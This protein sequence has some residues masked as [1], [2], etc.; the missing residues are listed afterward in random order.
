MV[1]IAILGYGVVGSGVYEVIRKNC[2]SITRK[3]G[4]EIDVKYILDIR[5]FPDHPENWLFTKDFDTILNDDDVSIVVEVMGG[6]EPA[7]PYTKAAL[8]KGKNVVTS[9][10]ELVAT[11]GDELLQIAHDNG[12]CYLFEA[13]VGG[14]IPIIRP[15]NQ[16]LAGNEITEIVGILNGTTNYILTQMIKNG[17]AFEDALKDAQDK[18]FAERNPAADV[19]G[20][21]A[22]RKICILASLA[23]GKKIAYDKVYTEGITNLTLRD[24]GYADELGS[25]IKL[26]GYCRKLDNGKVDI[27]VAPMMVADEQPLSTVAGVYN[28]IQVRGNAIGDAMFYGPGAGKLPTASAVVGDIIDIAKNPGRVGR[29]LWTDTK[30]DLILDTNQA[31]CAYFVRIAAQDKGKAGADVKALFGEVTVIDKYEDELGFLT[32]EMSE[33]TLKEKLTG[34]PYRVVG[35]IRVLS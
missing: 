3:A 22:C 34:L 29:V 1:N 35:F 5:Q 27:K 30:E 31:V 28:G 33:G 15:L 19:E 2:E 11:Y 18:G 21:D 12:V 24:T 4:Q 25:V 17:V 32:G 6:L 16:C 9:N 8:Q 7:Y 10:K 26:L 23:T 13:S 20:Y 14:G